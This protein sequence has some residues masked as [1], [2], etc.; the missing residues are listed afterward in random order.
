MYLLK[1]TDIFVD[2][3]ILKNFAVLGASMSISGILNQKEEQSMYFQN[4]LSS[5]S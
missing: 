4:I 3:S 1:K 5:F 2:S